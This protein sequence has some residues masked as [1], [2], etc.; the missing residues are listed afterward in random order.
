LG[1]SGLLIP[2]FNQ[3]TYE[4]KYICDQILVKFS[5]LVIEIWCSQGFW[6]A[7]THSLT[8]GQTRHCVSM[9]GEASNYM[10]IILTPNCTICMKASTFGVL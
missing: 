4:L 3:H 1:I 8:H 6:D 9:V 10:N 2:K 7:H 5:S